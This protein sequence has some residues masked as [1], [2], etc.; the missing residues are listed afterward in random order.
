MAEE[1]AQQQ[2]AEVNPQDNGLL[3]DEQDLSG[4]MAIVT[5]ATSG[6]GFE[7][8]LALARRGAHVMFGIRNLKKGAE[9]MDA[10]KE[11]VPDARVSLPGAQ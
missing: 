5:G 3:A 10:L 11:K 1:A 8:S 2:Q 4:K 9:Y 6:L 7:T